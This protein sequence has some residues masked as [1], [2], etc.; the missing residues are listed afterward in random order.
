VGKV[1]H[2][3]SRISD[4]KDNRVRPR[5]KTA[6]IF[7][8]ILVMALSRLGSLNALEQ[9]SEHSFWRRWLRKELPSVDT[10]SYVST[11]VDLETIR[12]MLKHV[13]DKLKRNKALKPIYPNSF[14]LVIDGHESNASY[15]RHCEGCLERKIHKNDGDKIQYYHRNVTAMLVCD[16]FHLFLDLET[17]RPGEDEVAAA[18]RLVE[19]VVKNYPRAFNIILADGLYARAS[20]FNCALKLGKDVIAVLK[21]DRRELIKD[22][23]GLSIIELPYTYQAGKTM[24]Q[25][26]DIENF[27]SWNSLKRE[28]RVVRSLETSSVCRQLTGA[29]EDKTSEWMWVTTI[30]KKKLPT[31]PF[32]EIAHKRWAI[33]N[34]GFNEL[35]TYWHADH[36]YRHDPAAI[37]SFWLMTMLAYNLFHAFIKLNLKPEFREKHTKLHFLE[38]ISA[39]IYSKMYEEAFIP[40]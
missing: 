39:E 15:L 13:Y 24:I 19:R 8:S 3:D 37:E 31:K 18:M 14:A 1:F 12:P 5:I 30:S 16:E 20:F 27:T 35:V 40:P 36:V 32:V 23:R 2:I 17:Q 22:A 21:D 4:V 9:T 7:K 38:M 11:K 6:T 26:W 33:E 34:E 10:V 28:V 29:I 25:C